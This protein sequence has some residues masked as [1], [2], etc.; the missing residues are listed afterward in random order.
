MR[1]MCTLKILLF[2]QEHSALILR[3]GSDPLPLKVLYIRIIPNFTVSLT[4]SL[5]Y[6]QGELLATVLLLPWFWSGDADEKP[7]FQ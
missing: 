2:I 6:H 5:K 4:T 3:K 1:K 7:V